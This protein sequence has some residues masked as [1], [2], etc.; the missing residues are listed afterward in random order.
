M[1]FPSI[2]SNIQT[3]WSHRVLSDPDLGH[4]HVTIYQKNP[5]MKLSHIRFSCWLPGLVLLVGLPLMAPAAAPVDFELPDL[6]GTPHRLAQYRGQ[7]VLVNFWATWCGPC[8]REIPELVAF[9]DRHREQAVVI[10]I[11][12][13]QTPLAEVRA[14]VAEFNINYPVLRIGGQPLLPFEPLK[15]LPSTFLV[16]PTG[17]YLHDHVGPITGAELDRMLERFAASNGQASN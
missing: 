9:Q 6:A 17:E 8:I 15:G 4:H 12:F 1:V 3:S 2:H 5:L 13:E 10:G 16:S 11:N 7:W 14:F